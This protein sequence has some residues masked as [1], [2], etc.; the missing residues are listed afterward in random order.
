[1]DVHDGMRRG[2]RYGAGGGRVGLDDIREFCVVLS[3]L[4]MIVVPKR[5]FRIDGCT[6]S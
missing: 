2:G 3:L 6:N 5:C 1:V 4:S